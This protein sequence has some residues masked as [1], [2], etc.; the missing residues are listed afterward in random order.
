MSGYSVLSRYYD[1]LMS[2]FPYKRYLDYLLTIKSGGRAADLFCGSGAMSV[3]LSRVGFE[4]LGVDLSAEMLNEAKQNAAAEGQKIVFVQASAADVELSGHYDLI[5]A[6]CD[7]V[8]YLTPSA[9]GRLFRNVEKALSKDGV[10]VFD[11]STEHK[12]KDVI[13]NNVFFEDYDDVTYLW[14]NKLTGSRVDMDLTFFIKENGGY[15]RK[16]E[17]QRQYIHTADGLKKALA[18]AKL[19]AESVIDGNSFGRVSSCSDRIIFKV[20]RT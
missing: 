3:P 17:S 15:V 5:T 1:R 8:N 14:R 16:D 10:F 12:L 13:G 11:V 19:K 7:G 9:V 4:V 18:E 20:K 2:D 6:V